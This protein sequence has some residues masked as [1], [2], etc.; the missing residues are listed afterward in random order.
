MT[1]D[2]HSC[3]SCTHCDQTISGFRRWCD[4][5]KELV[6]VKGEI[7]RHYVDTWERD[8]FG[9]FPNAERLGLIKHY[10]N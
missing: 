1:L 4:I 5:R 6:D 7:C 9:N 3:G 10:K 8:L 2:T